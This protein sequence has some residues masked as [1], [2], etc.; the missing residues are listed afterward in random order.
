[1]IPSTL[2]NISLMSSGPPFLFFETLKKKKRTYFPAERQIFP[3][4]S[5]LSLSFLLLPNKFS[6][7]RI[8]SLVPPL[9]VCSFLGHCVDVTQARPW[10]GHQIEWAFEA[11][12]ISVETFLLSSHLRLEASFPFPSPLS[13]PRLKKSCTVHPHRV[14]QKAHLL[15]QVALSLQAAATPTRST[16]AVFCTS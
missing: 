13:K 1:M 2:P 10:R 5:S 8:H 4:L 14:S 6:I 15:H 7:T 9:G 3:S 12:F 11:A 16:C